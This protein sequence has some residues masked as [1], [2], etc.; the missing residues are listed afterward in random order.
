MNVY[1]SQ[2]VAGILSQEGFVQ[3]KTVEDADIILFNTCSVRDSA[4]QR[5]RGRMAQLSALREQNPQL[6]LGIM[7]CMAQRLGKILIE[8]LPFLDLV[9]GT[10]AYIR[11]PETI[12]EILQK[13]RQ[14]KKVLVDVDAD[15]TYE[16]ITPYRE[17]PSSAFLTIMRGC[18]NYCSYCIVPY[19][20]GRERSRDIENVLADV[21]DI[22]DSGIKEVILLGQN[23]NSY[24]SGNADFPTLLRKIDDIPGVE[25]VRFT[26]SHPKDLSLDMIKTMAQCDSVCEHLHLAMQS[27]SNR[28]LKKMN[29]NYTREHYL[30]LIQLLREYLPKIAISTDVIVGFP[31]ETEADFQQTLDMMKRIRFDSAFMFRYSVRTGT[32]A[33]EMEN[34]V[35]EEVKLRRLS[36]LIELQHQISKEKM[37]PYIGN[38]EEVLV[39]KISLKDEEQVMGRTRTFK[40]VVFPGDE[41]LIGSLVNVTI[42]EAKGLTLLGEMAKNPEGS[43]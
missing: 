7:G 3:A 41:K 29:R 27:G 2:L 19:V 34:D 35:P 15:L 43:M 28:I 25:R 37:T 20:R 38:I 32:R 36:E 4:E 14:Q 42:K 10:D 24:Q 33:A 16:N 9:I 30:N 6:I 31:T 12:E 40:S 13:H 8:E 22:V 11:L 1:D 5:V 39:E 21:E 17:K 26:S 18:N 23:V